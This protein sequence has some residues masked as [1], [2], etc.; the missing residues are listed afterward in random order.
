MFLYDKIRLGLDGPCGAVGGEDGLRRGSGDEQADPVSSYCRVVLAMSARN[1]R[2][3]ALWRM[4]NL[5][6]G[7]HCLSS[8]HAFAI[9]VI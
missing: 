5:D 4:S 9:T 7:R 3:I 1:Y 6:R 2:P 8:N